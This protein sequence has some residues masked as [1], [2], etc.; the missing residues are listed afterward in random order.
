[1]SDSYESMTWA[2]L[3]A[4][5]VKN[6]LA[7]WETWVQFVN[8]DDPLEKGMATHSGILTWRILQMEEPDRLQPMGSQKV[9]QDCMTNTNKIR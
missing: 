3:V 5:T 2:S 4:Q 6:L 8:M 7:E 1:M 9:R